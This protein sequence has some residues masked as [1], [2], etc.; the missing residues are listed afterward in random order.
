MFVVTYDKKSADELKSK[1]ARV[2]SEETNNGIVK[3]RFIVD[4]V[5]YD[6]LDRKVFKIDNK[7]NI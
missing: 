6:T 4:L 1:G 7:F 5:Q 3:T 2:V